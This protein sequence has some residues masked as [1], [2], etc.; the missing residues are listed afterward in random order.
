VDPSGEQQ[1]FSSDE[2]LVQRSLKEFKETVRLHHSSILDDGPIREPMRGDP[3]ASVVP[4]AKRLLNEDGVQDDVQQMKNDH[5]VRI[6][7]VTGSDPLINEKVIGFLNEIPAQVLSIPKPVGQECLLVYSKTQRPID[8]GLMA[9]QETIFELGYLAAKFNR[10]K[11][12][13]L[14][15][16]SDDFLR[17]TEFFDLF[18]VPI[19]PSGSWKAEVT[20][21]MKGNLAVAAGL[22]LSVDD[23][24]S[25]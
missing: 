23:Q 12:V 13:V 15:E 21:R 7:C 17:P 22:G 8:G 2:D 1:Q 3:A 25:G 19:T 4:S 14:Y 24:S 10:Q 11:L 16:E 20:R 9:S 6:L 5:L 18:Y